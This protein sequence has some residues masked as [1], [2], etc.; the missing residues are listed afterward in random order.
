[1]L[2]VNVAVGV[3]V[4]GTLVNTTGTNILGA[5]GTFTI[6]STGT[7]GFAAGTNLNGLA[8][9]ESYQSIVN[10]TVQGV[11]KT[12]MTNDSLGTLSAII[13]MTTNGL[14]TNC[15]ASF[16][17]YGTST[18]QNS[19][20]PDLGS[21]G[22]YLAGIAS[23]GGAGNS[24]TVTNEGSIKIMA[25]TRPGFLRRALAAMAERAEVEAGCTAPA[26]AAPGAA[27]ARSPSRQ[28]VVSRRFQIIRAVW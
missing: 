14:V 11:N 8:V 2:T 9:G 21:Y 28:T 5:G 3:P 23:A 7:F 16:A 27:G 12:G 13:A 6:S 25:P 10:Y 17:T 20:L 18:N 22:Q 1:M 26:G 15:E 4:T 24:V 19:A